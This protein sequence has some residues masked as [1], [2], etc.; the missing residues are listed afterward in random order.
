MLHSESGETPSWKRRYRAGRDRTQL[1]TPFPLRPN[2]LGE[3]A[4]HEYQRLATADDFGR[5][6]DAVEIPRR[7][8]AREPQHMIEMSM[9]QQYVLQPAK[10]EPGA[11]QLALGP[12]AAVDQK[13]ARPASDEYR[14]QASLG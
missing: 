13:P 8:E 9:R 11:Q 3:I 7:E 5:S 12:L 6:A 2:R 1:V 10:P 4:A 14:R